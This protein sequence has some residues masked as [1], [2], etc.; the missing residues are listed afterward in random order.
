MNRS[1]LFNGVAMYATIAATIAVFPAI[2]TPV[3]ADVLLIEE[4]RAAQ[5]RDLPSN[6]ITKSEVEQRFGTPNERRSPVGDPPIT[7][8]VYDDFSVYFEYDRVISSV[9]HRGAVLSDPANG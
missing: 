9:L 5:S 8:W 2:P 1:R 3:S 6:G 4:V 7:R